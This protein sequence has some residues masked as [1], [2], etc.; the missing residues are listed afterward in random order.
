MASG[1]IQ[2]R[3]KDSSGS[4]GGWRSADEGLSDV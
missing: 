4:E 3:V 2:N 1:S